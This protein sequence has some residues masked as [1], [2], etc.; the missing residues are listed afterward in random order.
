MIK[1][2]IAN[3]SHSIIFYFHLVIANQHVPYKNDEA[4]V[5]KTGMLKP[6]R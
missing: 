5:K 4:N 6:V 2:V 1:A 3:N